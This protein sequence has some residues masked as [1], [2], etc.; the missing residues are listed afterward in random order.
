[1]TGPCK[2]YLL[3]FMMW[4]RHF[5]KSLPM[6]SAKG[7]ATRKAFVNTRTY[8]TKNQ[9]SK[10]V[11]P[12]FLTLHPDLETC[13]KVWL[14]GWQSQ[15]LKTEHYFNDY[16]ARKIAAK[17]YNRKKRTRCRSAVLVPLHEGWTKMIRTFNHFKSHL[18]NL[19][20]LLI[21][22]HCTKQNLWLFHSLHNRTIFFFIYFIFLFFSEL[23]PN[24]YCVRQLTNNHR[25][26][27]LLPRLIFSLI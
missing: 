24:Q 13:D 21:M 15:H 6:L 4:E 12:A 26:L 3:I 19:T 5:W 8:H 9:N 22:L 11:P 23:Y 2:N 14:P 16:C 20:P 1:M 10:G 25:K 18:I 27:S 17:E 7:Y